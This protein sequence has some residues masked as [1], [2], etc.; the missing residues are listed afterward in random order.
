MGSSFKAFSGLQKPFGHG[1]GF[2][3]KVFGENWEVINKQIVLKGC[4]GSRIDRLGHDSKENCS[5]NIKIAK[6]MRHKVI[7]LIGL[8][9]FSFSSICI[10]LLILIF[11][12]LKLNLSLSKAEFDIWSIW[13][14]VCFCVSV[15]YQILV[16][17]REIKLYKTTGL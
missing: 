13:I 8:R 11:L 6:K 5:L 9:Y 7:C 4:S 1:C 3:E 17:L 10:I 16:K 12:Y 2:E 15:F 14:K